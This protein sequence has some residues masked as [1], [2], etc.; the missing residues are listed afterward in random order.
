MKVFYIG[1]SRNTKGKI[2]SKLLMWYMGKKYSH[3]FFKFSDR[4]ILHSEIENGVNYWT[5]ERFCDVNTITDMYKIEVSQNQY[6]D[7]R[8][9]LNEHIGHKYAFW[10][11]IGIILVDLLVKFGI[12]KD[13][14]FRDGDNCSELVFRCLQ[15]LHPELVRQYKLNTIRPDHIEEILKKYNYYKVL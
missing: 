7:L 4:Y 11:N 12:K 14:P 10:Q 3:T 13:N 9:R 15:R 2:F 1:F 5:L 8:E 6:I